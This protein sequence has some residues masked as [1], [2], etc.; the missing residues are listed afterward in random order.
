[1]DVAEVAPAY[2]QAEISALAMEMICPYAAQ[3]KF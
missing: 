1:M 3:H 2:D